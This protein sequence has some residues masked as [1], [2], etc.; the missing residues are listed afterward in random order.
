MTPQDLVNYYANLLVIQYKGLPAA[1]ATVEMMAAMGIMP[2]YP[3][4]QGIGFN[5]A[6][7][8]GS[9]VVGFGANQSAAINWNDSSA[10]VQAKLRAVP[11]LG[12][13]QVTGTLAGNDDEPQLT[14]YMYGVTPVPAPLLTIVS[15]TIMGNQPGDPLVTEDLGSLITTESGEE[16]TTESMSVLAAV[17]VTELDLTLP[18]AIMNG[19]NLLG[20]YPAVGMQLDV[21]GKYAGV[22]RSGY[23]FQGQPITLS[24]SDFLQLINM[25][26]LRNNSGSS[27][28]TIDALLQQYFPGDVE[29]FDNANMQMSYLISSA[30]STNL[31]QLFVTE[32]LLPKPMGVE[33]A[34]II[35]VPDINDLFGFGGY[36]LPIPAPNRSPYNTYS[37]YQTNR[38]WLSYANAI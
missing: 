33:L 10:T 34:A 24:D 38:P 25:A 8:S 17:T 28:G 19:Y 37:S 22:T 5:Y 35:Y 30:L 18:L 3:T 23:G 29:V 2:Q 14:V 32:G 21:L 27:L 20:P 12:S 31:V 1:T 6:P 13:V 4:V 26:I 7:I 9:F 11:G 15:S 16:L 36:T